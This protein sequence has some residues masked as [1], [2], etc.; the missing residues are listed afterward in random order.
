MGRA[1][2]ASEGVQCGRK[3]SVHEQR[4]VQCR[5]FTRSTKRWERKCTFSQK[6]AGHLERSMG[7]SSV[8]GRMLGAIQLTGALAP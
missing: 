4:R 2:A 8:K 7:A 3:R 5:R 6:G 1:R